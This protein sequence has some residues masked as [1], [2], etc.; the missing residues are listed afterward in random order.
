MARPRPEKKSESQ[1]AADTKILAMELRV[2][3]RLTDE[4]GERE[5]VGVPLHPLAAR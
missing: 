3:D 4:S 2:G 5:V 1:A